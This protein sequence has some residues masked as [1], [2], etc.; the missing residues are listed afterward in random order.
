VWRF[1]AVP[2]DCLAE[3]AA[4]IYDGNFIA[5]AGQTDSMVFNPDSTSQKS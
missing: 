3:M 5:Q 2:F 1:L 4:D